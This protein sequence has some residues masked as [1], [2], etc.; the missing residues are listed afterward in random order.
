MR[1]DKHK[2]LGEAYTILRKPHLRG[3]F[4]RIFRIFSAFPRIFFQFRR[5]HPPP[6][7]SPLPGEALQ[8]Y[9]MPL[10]NLSLGPGLCASGPWLGV[11]AAG[12]WG[13]EI[14]QYIATRQRSL[15]GANLAVY[16]H[17]IVGSGQWGSFTSLPHCHTV[18]W[19]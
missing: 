5:P 3:I 14:L 2:G 8:F 19:G 10:P 15:G 18:A 11:D 13:A 6:P 12:S 16:G 4:C 1:L 7:P 9:L 17:T